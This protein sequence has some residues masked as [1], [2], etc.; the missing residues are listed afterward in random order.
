ME[1]KYGVYKKGL[2]LENVVA[3]PIAVY[4]SKEK[5]VEHARAAY[6]KLTTAE[7]GYNRVSYIVRPIESDN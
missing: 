6:S 4:T 5:A 7:K 2:N 3:K 1:Q